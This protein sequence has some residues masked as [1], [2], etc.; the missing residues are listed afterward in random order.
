MLLKGIHLLFFKQGLNRK[1]EAATRPF[2]AKGGYF[3]L[4]FLAQKLGDEEV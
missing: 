3:A 2:A 1:G 4:E